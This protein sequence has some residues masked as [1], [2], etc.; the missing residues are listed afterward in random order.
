MKFSSL[1]SPKPKKYTYSPLP[2]N[3]TIRLVQLVPDPTQQDGFSLTLRAVHIDEAPPFCALSYT[4]QRATASTP[5][6]MKQSEQDQAPPPVMVAVLCDEKRL[7]VTENA[8]D[9][10][11][12]AF[13]D[14]MF[15]ADDDADLA[16]RY[17]WMDAICINQL[18]LAE[19]SQQVALMGD[20]YVRSRR[21]TVWLGKDEPD[22]G[23]QWVMQNFIP[24]FLTAFERKKWHY[25]ASKHPQCID[26]DVIA[27]L[28][29]DIC[30]G[31]RRHYRR[32][33][34]FL[35]QRRWFYRGWVVQEVV[36]KA[37]ENEADVVVFCGSNFVTPWGE[38]LRFLTALSDCDW[39]RTITKGLRAHPETRHWGYRFSDVLQFAHSLS[40]TQDAIVVNFR[41]LQIGKN[42]HQRYEPTTDAER[43]HILLFNL[44]GA[45]RGRGFVDKR[46]YIYGCHGLVSRILRAD[47]GSAHPIRPDYLLTDAEVYT[48]TAWLMVK[49]MP[50]LNLLNCIE[51]AKE[52]SIP[53]LPSWV[54]DFSVGSC[55]TMIEFSQRR[56]GHP[57]RWFSA[58]NTKSPTSAFRLTDHNAL[59][60]RGV[61]LSAISDIGPRLYLNEMMD[62]EWFL[63]MLS[64]RETHAPT[65]ETAEE[66]LSRTL[67]A[68]IFPYNLPSESCGEAFCEWWTTALAQRI[69]KLEDIRE[70]SG[71]VITELLASL[72]NRSEWF[73]SVEQV[74]AALNES[75]DPHPTSRATGLGLVFH[76]LFAG[77]SK[78]FFVTSDGHFGVANR[79]FEAGDEVWI[80]EGGRTPFILRSCGVTGEYRLI[81]D[82][83]VHGVMYGE[84]MTVEMV[85][86]VG[87]VTLR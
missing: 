48:R 20:I 61:K 75:N 7:L 39:R 47:D 12:R 4:W 28:G 79:G 65:D 17:V 16:T 38:L 19:R 32:F 29:E 72:G 33:F 42:I 50:Y 27:E 36:L 82:T 18:D 9:F 56:E 86:R 37:V 77:W 69:Q 87:C 8:F 67:I 6:E 85:E 54:P 2:N 49:H 52:R 23:A 41:G 21:T 31:W 44:V 71:G 24:R 83:Y 66:A 30:A 63:R 81:G 68:N 14:G 26:A 62:S 58:S 57:T 1:F 11:C 70:G 35:A 22:L 51:P 34:L 13:R 74:L 73:P 25:F 46:D 45:M 40:K 64:E 15:R 60:L 3:R 80:L 53:S 43:I 5:D 10:L 55:P 59:V 76:R 78:M 84:A